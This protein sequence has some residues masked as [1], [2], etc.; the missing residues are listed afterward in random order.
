M[1][2][3]PPAARVFGPENSRDIKDGACLTCLADG[4]VAFPLDPGFHVYQCGHVP[5]LADLPKICAALDIAVER[6]EALAEKAV[7]EA[8]QPAVTGEET[9]HA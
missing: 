9:S 6:W 2:E 5:E 8:G 4:V 1:R 7:R 3:N